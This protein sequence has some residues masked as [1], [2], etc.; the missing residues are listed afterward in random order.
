MRLSTVTLYFTIIHYLY[1][2]AAPGYIRAQ[3]HGFNGFLQWKDVCYQWFEVKDTTVECIDG[4]RPS[5]VITIDVF[6]VDLR[7]GINTRSRGSNWEYVL[8]RGRDA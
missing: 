5:V 4:C 3:F 6:K 2:D 1:F 7:C 8:Q